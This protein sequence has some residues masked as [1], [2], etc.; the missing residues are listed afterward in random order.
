[1]ARIPHLTALSYLEAAART[2]SFVAAA[3]ELH[4]T[5][6][7]ISHQIKALED[8]LGVQLFVRHHRR[9]SLTPAARSALARLQ[10][11]FGALEGAVDQLRMYGE[12]KWVITVCAEPLLA[13]KWI[14]PRLHIVYHRYPE[15]EVRLQASLNTVDFAPDSTLNEGAFKR[16]GVDISVRLGFGEYADLDSRLLM[17]L[18]MMPMC[19]PG[20]L[21]QLTSY[22]A[23]M[24]YPLIADNTFS[25][26]DNPP[27]WTAWFQSVGKTVT[28]PLREQRFGNGLLALEAA[29]SG[30]GVV[31]GCRDLVEAEIQSGSLAVAFDQ[32]LSCSQAYYVVSPSAHLKRPIAQGFHDWLLEE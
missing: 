16:A 23:L 21:A 9:V 17:Q 7:A 3:K 5:P 10:E 14:V 32:A 22:D 26:F 8:Y 28:K 30:H 20:M 2:K 24:D 19:T 18:D 4:V 12:S 11:G 13:T 1:M 6:A 29:V 25:R 27:G 15:A 31:L